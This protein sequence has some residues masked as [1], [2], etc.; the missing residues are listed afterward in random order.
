MLD[1][2]NKNKSVNRQKK[3]RDAINHNKAPRFGG[4][5]NMINHNPNIHK[6]NE[7]T[8][9]IVS[10]PQSVPSQQHHK[11]LSASKGQAPV[12]HSVQEMKQW[13]KT[14]PKSSSSRKSGT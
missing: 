13:Q 9:S 12:F 4:D 1:G 3:I 11:N 2:G 6:G 5:P 10:T 14:H 8:R 7:N